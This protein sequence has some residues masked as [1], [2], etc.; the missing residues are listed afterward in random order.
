VNVN[1]NI[2]I[3]PTRPEV[4]PERSETLHLIRVAG[5]KWMKIIHEMVENRP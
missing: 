4:Q 3:C 2:L 5:R 1:P